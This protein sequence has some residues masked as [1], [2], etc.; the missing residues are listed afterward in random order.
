M[1]GIAPSVCVR[2]PCI[3]DSK[4][5]WKIMKY[6]EEHGVSMLNLY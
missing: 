1:D 4:R 5:D 3:P 6:V 2:E